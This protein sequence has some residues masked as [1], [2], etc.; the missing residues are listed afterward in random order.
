MGKIAVTGGAGF[1]GSHLA[2]GLLERGH[3]LVIIDNLSAGSMENLRDLGV[4][5]DCLVGDL[6]EYSFAKDALRDVE[7]VWHFAAEV[8]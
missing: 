6:R 5:Q 3:E 8:G 7:T 4:K 2:K 1:L